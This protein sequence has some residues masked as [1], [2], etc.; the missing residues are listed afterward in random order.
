MLMLA[1]C[2]TG[3][4][5][6]AQPIQYSESI[7]RPVPPT[8]NVSSVY[9]AITEYGDNHHGGVGAE[10]HGGQPGGGDGKNWFFFQT[11]SGGRKAG[12]NE[13]PGCS[14]SRNS[15]RTHQAMG[16]PSRANT[17]SKEAEVR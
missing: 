3:S 5:A 11:G 16:S 14:I 8:A 6:V 7:A 12:R 13:K 10:S 9:A 15:S 1:A 4:M 17:T 2:L